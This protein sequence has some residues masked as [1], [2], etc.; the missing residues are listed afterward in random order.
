[1]AI[2]SIEFRQALGSFASGVT[3]V[4]TR[5]ETGEFFGIT[6]SAFSSVSLDPPLIMVC[7]DKSSGSHDAFSQSGEFVVNI[8]N[9]QQDLLSN[10][11]ASPLEDKFKNIEVEHCESGLPMLPEALVSLECKL[12]DTLDGGDHTIYLGLIEKAHIREG[13]PLVYFKGG[14]RELTT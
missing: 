10:H 3:V 13:E 5:G 8:L 11:F 4:T 14:Y 2:G 1:M 12:A 7:I 9:S 6:V